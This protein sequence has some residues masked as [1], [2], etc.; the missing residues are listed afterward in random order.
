MDNNEKMFEIIW[1]KQKA[2]IGDPNIKNPKRL[3]LIAGVPGSGKTTLLRV[4]QKE[5]N[6][7]Y[8]R[9]D[10][11]RDILNEEYADNV[12]ANDPGL[13]EQYLEYIFGKYILGFVNQTLILDINMDRAYKFLLQLADKYGYPRMII[14]LNCSKDILIERLGKRES[15]YVNEFL[16][17][18]PKWV[19][20]HDD[21]NRLNMAD[22]VFNTEGEKV[23]R[24]VKEIQ[25]KLNQ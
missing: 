23:D 21:F 24:M 8:I 14:S 10:D 6:A 11:I 17:N 16:K 12:L 9:S 18:L 5:I 20:D 7:L 2:L 4:L 22:V 3:I 19:N 1:K 13:K 15:T 25:R